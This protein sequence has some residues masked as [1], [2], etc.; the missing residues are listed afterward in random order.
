MIEYDYTIKIYM[1]ADNDV[2]KK[3]FA[4]KFLGSVRKEDSSM[5]IGV[6]FRSKKIDIDGKILILQ[7]W[8]ASIEERFQD[9]WKMYIRGSLGVIL[10]YDITNE[11]SLNKLSEWIPLIRDSPPILLVG[12]KLDL[13]SNRE[14]SK[15]LVDIFKEKNNISDSMEISLQTG[16]N[17]EN[18]FRELIEMIL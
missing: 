3:T 2:G 18:M 8:I 17:V 10:M 6:D 16:E 12:N 1:F 13:G 7:F 5:T 15:E 14:V 11:E 9:I 4:Q